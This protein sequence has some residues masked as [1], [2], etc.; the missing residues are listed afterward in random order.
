[1]KVVALAGGV[2]GAKL[3]DGLNRILPR[4]DLTVIVNTGDDFEHCGLKICP[5]LDTVCY[6]LAGLGNPTTGW[7]R[8]G[9]TW[10][11]FSN[12]KNLGGPDWFQL[13]DR[14]LGTHLERTRRMKSGEKLSDVTRHFAQVWGIQSKILPMT[15]DS[16]ETWIHTADNGVLAFQE[17]F[18]KYGCR[19][20][21]KGFEFRGEIGSQA[22][23]GVL[24]AIQDSDFVVV[25]PSNPMVSI[26]PIRAV[27]QIADALS[28]KQHIVAVSPIINGK[29]IKGPAA[30]MYQELGLE[31]SAYEVALQYKNWVETLFIDRSDA[32][33]ASAIEGIGL[34]VVVDDILMSSIEDRMRLAEQVLASCRL[35][36]KRSR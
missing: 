23:P 29:A 34:K 24:T 12:I 2:G 9:E 17:Y 6:T 10:N 5:D 32:D 15:D 26:G 28:K 1:M 20:I 11:A 13:G 16:L 31:P 7:G 3:A 18:V 22:A 30:K 27:R 21:V 25:C 19:P 14:D 36:I 4:G 35:A 33:L 8:E